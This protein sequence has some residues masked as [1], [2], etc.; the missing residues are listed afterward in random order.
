LLSENIVNDRV[1][2]DENEN[3]LESPREE[4]KFSCEVEFVP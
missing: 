4:I 3:D 1:K 2:Y